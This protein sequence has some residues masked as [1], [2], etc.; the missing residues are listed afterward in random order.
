MGYVIDTKQYRK[1]VAAR[2]RPLKSPLLISQTVFKRLRYAMNTHWKV[3]IL[4][5]ST[6]ARLIYWKVLGGLGRRR[7]SRGSNN[8][9]T[10]V[11]PISSQIFNALFVDRLLRLEDEIDKLEIPSSTQELIEPGEFMYELLSRSEVN[12][13]NFELLQR[14]ME[15][16]INIL[17]G[18]GESRRTNLLCDEY[19]SIHFT[20]YSVFV[21][22]CRAGWGQAASQVCYQSSA[23][24]AQ[25]GV[26]VRFLLAGGAN[27]YAYKVL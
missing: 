21:E 3:D 25:D 7:E 12:G 17:A 6:L 11:R 13:S 8:L 5:I 27:I 18:I 4:A 16:A 23:V 22:Y 2:R 1:A 14:V 15:A 24:S 19:L 20:D 9:D 10:D 26:P